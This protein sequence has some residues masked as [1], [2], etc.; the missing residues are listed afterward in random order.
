MSDAED[1]VAFD[2]PGPGGWKA[3]ADHFP[4]AV[5]P[6]Y[7]RLY[8]E[9]C[10]AGMATYMSRY[11]VLARTLD[12]GYVHGHLY[13]TPVPL[14]GPREM[15]W[16][17]PTVAVWL[18]ARLHPEFRRR[19]RA[20]RKALAERPWRTTA[21][22]WFESERTTWQHRAQQL[23]EV[24]LSALAESELVDHLRDAQLFVADGYQRHFELHGDD[25]LPIGLLLA[26]CAEWGIDAGTALQSLDGI[27]PPATTIAARSWRLATGYDLDNLTW[28]ELGAAP[29]PPQIGEQEPLDLRPLVPA[30]HRAELD[31]L[32][33]DARAAVPLRDDNGAV[34]GAW[35]MGLLRRAMLEAG[36]RLELPIPG[37]AVEATVDELIERLTHTGGPSNNELADRHTDRQRRSNLDA[38]RTLGPEFA[39]PPLDPLPRALALIGAAQL[40]AA[41]H[42][43]EGNAPIGIGNQT[44]TGRAL[45]I[46]DPNEAL[47]LIEPGDV[48]ITQTTSPAWNAILVHAG[49][50]V[51]TTG[52]LISHAAII[53][54]ELDIPA[55]I[56]D[57][58]A[59]ARLTTG[60]T[61]IVDPRAAT[62]RTVDSSRSSTTKSAAIA[63]SDPDHTPTRR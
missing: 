51:T 44:H 28:H 9:T 41:D 13:I 20:A 58:T 52:G 57:P 32:V 17:P 8:A 3:L 4:G 6:E 19:T 22:Q 59:V 39:I 43:L 36:R 40:A 1:T 48:V 23:E 25:L 55:V 53:A 54:R 30:E 56:G 5:T 63:D 11:G 50:I 29:T 60:T 26:R 38:P 16:T 61:V 12:V 31:Q 15:R 27:T 34:T 45:V 18:M 37:H 33:S 35:P 24:D 21:T 14:A 46:N 42:M 10:P 47:E 7:Q 49:A 2:P 62:V